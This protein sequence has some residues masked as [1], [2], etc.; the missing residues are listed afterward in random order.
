MKLV[1][2]FLTT[3]KEKNHTAFKKNQNFN[4]DMAIHLCK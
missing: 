2:I 1:L 4:K 3:E